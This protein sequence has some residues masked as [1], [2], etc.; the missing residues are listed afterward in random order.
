MS[1]EGTRVLVVDD[2]ESNLKVLQRVLEKEGYQ[3]DLANN[4]PEGLDA[5]R[6]ASPALLLTDLKMPGM[7]GLELLKAAR[8][9]SPATEVILMT[10]HGT[11]ELAV[12]AMKEGAYDFITKPLKRHD[13]VRAV[14]KGIEKAMLVS[15]NRRLREQIAAVSGEGPGAQ[16]IG[17]SAPF[18]AVMDVIDQVAPSEA[19]VLISGES[20][21]GKE[22]LARAIHRLSA[23]SAEAMIA[24]NCAAIPENLIESELFGYEKGAFTGAADRKPGRFELADGGTLFLDEVGEL[25][26]SAQVKLLRAI[27]EGEFERVGGTTTVAVDVRI[28]AA[29]NRDLERAVAQRSFREDLYYRLNVIPLKLPPLRERRDDISLLAAFFVAR[30]ALR[31]GKQ[32]KGITD[33]ALQALIA[34]RWPGNIRELENC[35][36]RAV[37]LCRTD[38]LG[39]ADLPRH[40]QPEGHGGPRQIVFAIGTPLRELERVAID[41]TLRYTGGDK[42]L[43]ARLLG[44][45]AR[46]IYRRLEGERGD[47]ENS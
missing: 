28:V 33:E 9:V 14:G 18:R 39:A 2:E 22:V 11:V 46:T 25:S 10:A 35:I 43:A 21:T 19:T 36:E 23:R 38:Q 26:S 27:Q 47:G 5:L 20:G 42:K 31:N 37:V 7:D 45:A 8:A 30:Y 34:Y 32:I 16:V 6:A 40:M 17:R 24:V 15:E 3:V 12:E 1:T 44:I 4:G 41:E 29:T 13:I